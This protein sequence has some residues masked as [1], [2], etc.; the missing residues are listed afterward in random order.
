M[1][2]SY[3]FRRAG[4]VAA[5]GCRTAVPG[6]ANGDG[7]A[8]VAVSADTFRSAGGA[9]QI[10]YGRSRTIHRNTAGVTGGLIRFG[11]FGFRVS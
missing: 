5:T 4:V 8:E 9:V 10:F 1:G 6:G 7:H 3:G 11:Q 2:F